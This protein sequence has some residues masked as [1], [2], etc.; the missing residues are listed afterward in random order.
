MASNTSNTVSVQAAQAAVAALILDA[1]RVGFM[2]DDMPK[3]KGIRPL[4]GKIEEGEV[5][6][7]YAD[8][9][10]ARVYLD[11]LVGAMSWSDASA[12]RGTW[13][14]VVFHGWNISLIDLSKKAGEVLGS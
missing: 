12:S 4:F 14:G 1:D 6:I 5:V 13:D 9:D 10:D 2:S 8:N 11:M 7:V 3:I